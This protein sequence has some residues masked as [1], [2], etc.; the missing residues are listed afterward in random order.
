[1]CFFR[2]RILKCKL[3]NI[4]AGCHGTVIEDTEIPKSLAWLY[5][6]IVQVLGLVYHTE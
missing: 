6:G 3:P 5:C 4:L 1:M 2:M